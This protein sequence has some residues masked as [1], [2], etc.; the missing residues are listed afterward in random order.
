MVRA[1]GFTGE[2]AGLLK[3][4]WI[5]KYN[6]VNTP[7]ASAGRPNTTSAAALARDQPFNLVL[8][9]GLV[10]SG[11]IWP[12]GLTTHGASLPYVASH[13]IT[14]ANP[15]PQGT[16]CP[17]TSNDMTKNAF[18][19][20]NMMMGMQRL[21]LHALSA[22]QPLVPLFWIQRLRRNV[23]HAPSLV[24]RAA[25]HRASAGCMRRMRSR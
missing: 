9:T 11:P 2:K 12:A 25:V 18:S 23:P 10:S 6:A 14:G 4:K 3:E 16:E 5:A 8:H 17:Y 24:Q 15:L 21:G 1:M 13:H 7:S 19:M 20:L 22:Y